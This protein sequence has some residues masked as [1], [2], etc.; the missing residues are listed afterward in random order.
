[1][2]C[3]ILIMG[4][5][6]VASGQSSFQFGGGGHVMMPVGDYGGSTNDFYLGSKY[7]AGVGLGFHFKSRFE[8]AGIP[9]MASMEY[10]IFK[11]K[12]NGESS[13]GEIELDRRIFSLRLGPEWFLDVA[14]SF[15][16][17]VSAGLILNNMGGDAGFKKISTVPDTAFIQ[18]AGERLGLGI[19]GGVLIPLYPEANF[20][21]SL[22]YN[23][24]NPFNK[25]WVADS[26]ERRVDSYAAI[27]DAQDPLS[28]SGNPGHFIQNARSIQTL[29]LTITLIFRI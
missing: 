12:G 17:Y 19:S 18:Q 29:Q 4:A 24:M 21:I 9:W 26:R 6:C 8:F 5:S 7:G 3:L 20:D 11:N 13:Q 1:M 2:K 14:D 23:L 25:V 27:N 15:T 28:P 10:S 16:P 22:N